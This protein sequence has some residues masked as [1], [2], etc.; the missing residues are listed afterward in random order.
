MK[1]KR[2]RRNTRYFLLLGIFHCVLLLIVLVRRK[3]RITLVLLF[4]NM[5][6]AYLFDYLILNLFNAYTYKPHVMKNRSLDNIFGAIL[7]QDVYVPVGATFIT[8]FR[9]DWRWKISFS[10]YFYFIE[11]LFL[12]L[13]LYTVHWWRSYYTPIFL[14]LYFYLSDG[15]YIVLKNKKK[16]ALMTAQYLSSAVVG[17][18]L[19]YAAAAGRKLR[20]GW[21]HRHSWKEH[22]MIAPLYS[23]FLS[24]IG[25]LVSFQAKFIYRLL[26]L[27]WCTIFDFI[28]MKTGVLKMQSRQ[29]LMNIPFHVFMV[30]ISTFLNRA[31]YKWGK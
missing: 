5:G 4:T 7:S 9:G 6:F 27:V 13:G 11:K 2:K 26:F 28:L 12:K 16:W 3:Q 22:F 18:S 31:I 17:V 15:A 14:C 8:A 20:F 29:V 10:L 23:M 1:R 19:L 24:L 21:K 30:Y 25:T